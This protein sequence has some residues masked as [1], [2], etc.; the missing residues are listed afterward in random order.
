MFI[1]TAALQDRCANQGC[2][3]AGTELVSYKINGKFLCLALCAECLALL[4]GSDNPMAT[5]EAVSR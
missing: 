5:A 2:Q 4:E 3:R 1:I